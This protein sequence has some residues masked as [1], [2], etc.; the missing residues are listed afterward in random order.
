[1]GFKMKKFISHYSNQ[2]SYIYK[3][4]YDDERKFYD[5][6]VSLWVYYV[7]RP[8]SIAFTPIFTK[9]NVSANQTTVI[10]FIFGLVSLML[11]AYGASINAAV[12]YNI[13]LIFDSIDGN[14]ARLSQP[15]KRG[16]LLD[17]IT[18]DITNFLFV[19]CL[20]YGL[21][22]NGSGNDNLIIFGL[23]GSLIHSL[24][25][26]FAQRKKL[27]FNQTSKKP[28]R[29]FNNNKIT[30]VELIIRNSFGFAFIAP[31]SLILSIFQALQYLVLYNLISVSIVFTYTL[32]VT[33][34]RF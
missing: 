7:T 21:H 26:L 1:M 17:A 6:L 27:I 11:A 22:Q 34:R 28:A 14:I 16:E 13:F 12:F 2:F 32:Y 5:K 24:S 8:I 4:T 23:L 31:F 3:I 10:G 30:I 25:I 29:I 15:S 18:G 9:L 20:A 19:P 33:L